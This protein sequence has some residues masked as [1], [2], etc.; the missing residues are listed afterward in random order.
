MGLEGMDTL[1]KANEI[2]IQ[3]A[4]EIWFIRLSS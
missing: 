4:S 2:E 3:N 1:A